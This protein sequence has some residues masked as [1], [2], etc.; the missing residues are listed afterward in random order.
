M[1]RQRAVAVV[2][3][4]DVLR[5]R[6]A[7]V[8][9]RHR[10]VVS[11]AQCVGRRAGEVNQL[12]LRQLEAICPVVRFV[13]GV[14]VLNRVA[15]G[16][17][18]VARDVRGFPAQFR[19]RQTEQP[20]RVH[21]LMPEPERMPL[22]DNSLVQQKR[23]RVIHIRIVV[24]ILLRHGRARIERNRREIE[25]LREEL[26]VAGGI[27]RVACEVAAKF[28]VA[29]RRGKR[30]CT[31]GFHQRALRRVNRVRERVQAIVRRILPTV[32]QMLQF[33]RRV[34]MPLR[35]RGERDTRRVL[36]RMVDIS[37]DGLRHEVHKFALV[38]LALIVR[39]HPQIP[40][41]R[42][43]HLDVNHVRFFRHLQG[44]DA[45][46]VNRHAALVRLEVHAGRVGAF[47]RLFI[48]RHSAE[49][50]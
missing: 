10:L 47:E 29:S 13:H 27:R 48:H 23:Q 1:L 24:A 31:G 15:V 17:D 50:V 41:E 11:F 22:G 19:V 30:L 39:H 33:N 2:P 43:R 37:A 46:A 32:R 42:H 12:F 21:V 49:A 18:V 14:P 26:G 45:L 36:L 3:P 20:L 40:V 7:D 8:D 4:R 35:R 28:E 9:N 5:E 25:R 38:P 16:A 6:Q 34:K 44:H